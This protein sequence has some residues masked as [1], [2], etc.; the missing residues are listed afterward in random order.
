MKNCKEKTHFHF[1]YG[2]S[3][4]V[5]IP[6]VSW[7]TTREFNQSARDGARRFLA[8]IGRAK[9]PLTTYSSPPDARTHPL[10]P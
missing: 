9:R 1:F 10:E 3:R 7:Q 4:P 8:R 5:A 2:P 6:H